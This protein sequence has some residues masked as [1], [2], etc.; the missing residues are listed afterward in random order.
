MRNVVF[1]SGE[2][3]ARI[4]A[5][6]LTSSVTSSYLTSL[7]LC[8]FSEKLGDRITNDRKVLG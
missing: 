1:D 8:V 3:S 7:S 5:L 6:L 2:T 4:L